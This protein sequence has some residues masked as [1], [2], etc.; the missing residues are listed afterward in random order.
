MR[1]SR[2][3]KIVHESLNYL[4]IR[5]FDRI[6]CVSICLSFIGDEFPLCAAIINH[7][8]WTLFRSAFEQVLFDRIKK[9]TFIIICWCWNN[10]NFSWHTYWL[11]SFR[12]NS[13]CFL[14]QMSGWTQCLWIPVWDYL[15]C[16]I[17][18]ENIKYL[19]ACHCPR[20]II[21]STPHWC[22]TSDIWLPFKLASSAHIHTQDIKI[23][24]I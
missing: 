6:M 20:I 12:Y 18:M 11:N 19:N 5:A 2:F 21:M 23:L 10:E 9:W 24:C 4:T 13:L 8:N 17:Q 16:F 1:Y 7:F 3:R 22:Q 14:I 15:S